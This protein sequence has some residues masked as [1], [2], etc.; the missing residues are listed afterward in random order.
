MIGLLG[1]SGAVGAHAARLLSRHGADLRLGGR[2]PETVAPVAGELPG[3]VEVVR[4]DA[5]REASL[6]AFARGCTVVAN[7]AGPAQHLAEAAARTVWRAGAHYVDAGGD[8]A[9]AE[10]VAQG[11]AAGD[12]RRAVFAAGAWPGLSGLF[13]RWLAAREFATVHTLTAYI[14][15]RDRFTATAAADYLDGALDGASEPLAAWRQ[16]PRSRVLTRQIDEALPFF[17]EGVS[18]F[19]YLDHEGVQVARALGLT[20][21]DWYSVLPGTWGVA[22]DRARTRPRADAVADLCRASEVDAAGHPASTTLL[23]Q[24]DG[25]VDGVARTRTGLVQGPGVSELTGAVTAVSALAVHDGTVAPGTACAATALDP[26]ATLT[27][28][29]AAG[30]CR[31]T[32]LA[33]SIEAL[34]TVEAGAL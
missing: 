28:L 22:L 13:P 25:E 11:G 10:R 6:A 21:A 20:R 23:T 8:A 19:P 14:G 5:T 31:V 7:C 9:T 3:G 33:T 29:L 30:V 2:R 27:W 34:R 24:L 1:A 32:V 4:V 18:A 12:D 16:G 15:V 17:P 26:L